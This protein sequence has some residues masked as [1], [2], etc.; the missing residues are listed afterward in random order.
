MGSYLKK[1]VF[2]DNKG[3]RMEPVEEDVKG[4]DAFIER[5][6]AGLTVEREAVKRL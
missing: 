3:S 2:S 1:N 4:F 5:Y 6:Q